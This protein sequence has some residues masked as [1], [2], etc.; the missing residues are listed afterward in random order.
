MR[1][2]LCVLLS[3]IVPTVRELVITPCLVMILGSHAVASVADSH[4]D[5]SLDSLVFTVPRLARCRIIL[6]DL[7]RAVG[8]VHNT[9]YLLV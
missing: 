5:V 1:L 6:D 4:D 3:A 2:P 8:L 7:K 9:G